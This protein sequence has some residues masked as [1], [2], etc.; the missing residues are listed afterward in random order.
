MLLSMGHKELDT[1][2]RL[3]WTEWCWCHLK[4]FW[5][6]VLSELFHS[7]PWFSSGGFIAPLCFLPL[8]W[9]HLHIWASLVAQRVKNLTAI[10]ETW[11]RAL[12][13]ENPLEEGMANRLQYSCLENPRGQKSLV[14]YSPWSHEESDKTARL[15]RAQ[16]SNQY[17]I[18][19]RERKTRNGVYPT[20]SFFLHF[21]PKWSSD[22]FE[23]I[24]F[25]RFF[26]R[27]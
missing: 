9:Y 13:Q 2:E 24:K 6:L 12:G 18:W 27:G 10:R 23:I 1:T 19:I 15:S 25:K 5:Y 8:E 20:N 16:H 21:F 7:P 14:G 22:P 17:I 26:R 3:N 4:F 11:V